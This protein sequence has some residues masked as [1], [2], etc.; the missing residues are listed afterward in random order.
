[1]DC[2]IFLGSKELCHTY[3]CFDS[4]DTHLSVTLDDDE[5]YYADFKNGL[6]VW[7]SKIPTFAH[8]PQAYKYAV[9]YRAICKEWLQRWKPD[10]S[11]TAKPKGNR[12]STC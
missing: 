2:C 11:A 10:K 6:L 4:S 7:D 12:N 5:V 9:Y 1:M 3:G 8:V